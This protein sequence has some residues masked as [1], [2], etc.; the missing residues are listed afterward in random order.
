VV[1]RLARKKPPKTFRKVLSGCRGCR[2]LGE[3]L[4]FQNAHRCDELVAITDLGK[5]MADDF[6][7]VHCPKCN[8]RLK[9]AQR[10]HRSLVSS[11]SQVSCPKCDTTFRFSESP[12]TVTPK[13]KGSHSEVANP[14]QLRKNIPAKRISE[15]GEFTPIENKWAPKIEG[16]LWLYGL[17][18]FYAAI[19][20][21]PYNWYLE[22]DF[23]TSTT[24]DL[25]TTPGS[26]FF[27]PSWGTVFTLDTLWLVF[28]SVFTYVLA[29]F[30]VNKS[31]HF[32]TLLFVCAAS[33][34]LFATI[35]LVLVSQIDPSLAFGA[36]F[37][38]PFVYWGIW[39]PY[40]IYSKR[41]KR[42]FI[43]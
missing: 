10:V 25:L 43:Y 42:T 40:F 39:V 28:G 38:K 6:I 22:Y 29:Y 14:L 37:F 31:R 18:L 8:K 41:V 35:V 3:Q 4:P 33:N 23:A 27:H 5:V 24:R 15:L 26:E 1:L 19:L 17:S 12:A 7:R 36:D 16:W 11:G 34:L 32:P 2:L 13:E 20:G 21:N 9:V 30:Y